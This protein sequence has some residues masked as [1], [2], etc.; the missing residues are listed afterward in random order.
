MEA[1]RPPCPPLV[2]PG[3]SRLMPDDMT[4][5]F[6]AEL[7]LAQAQEQLAEHDQ[8]LPEDGDPA[9][10]LGQLVA[11]NSSGPLRVGYGAWRD[12]LLGVQFTNGL[13]RLITAGGITMKNVAGYDLT[14]LMV[15]QHGI[16]GRLVTIS[17]RTRRRPEGSLLVQL[18]PDPS[19][20]HSL[21]PTP[22]RPH[23]TI[24]TRRN[25]LLGYLGPASAIDFYE[26]TKRTPPVGS[27]IPD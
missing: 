20:L 6:S 7:T 9:L 3:Q 8:W 26:K 4:A 21:L 22:L 25:L 12:L 2:G 27:S 11:E 24:L 19:L 10:T 16:L 17:T 23:W 14:K 18:P 1:L 13:G 15:G 5:I